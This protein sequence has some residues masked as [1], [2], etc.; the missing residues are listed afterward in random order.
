MYCPP[1]PQCP[2]Q[3]PQVQCP[4]RPPPVQCPQPP[5]QVICP[6]NPPQVQ[7]PSCPPAQPCPPAY[8]AWEVP[9]SDL[10]P[11]TTPTLKILIKQSNSDFEITYNTQLSD[12]IENIKQ[13]I[14]NAEGIPVEK[15]ILVFDGQP[16]N[17]DKAL[18]YY[19]IQAE[20]IIYLELV[21]ESEFLPTAS[22]DDV[23][24]SSNFGSQTTDEAESQTT[25]EAESQ[26]TGEIDSQTTIE[27]ETQADEQEVSETSGKPASQS[28]FNFQ[29]NL[30]SDIGINGQLSLD[31]GLKLNSTLN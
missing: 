9:T 24:D 14:Q 3:P 15:Q 26:T 30:G 28:G 10:P 4:P 13:A 1:Q 19:N 23:D 17:N 31:S 21:D 25:D 11:Q 8:C 22:V 16:L 29:I 2:P 7:Q 20:S 12:T 5:P 6:Q 18:F 27:N